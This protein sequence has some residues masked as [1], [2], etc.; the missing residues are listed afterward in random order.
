MLEFADL[1]QQISGEMSVRNNTTT[2]PDH[3]ESTTI[4]ENTSWFFPQKIDHYIQK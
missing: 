4:L 1:K 3:L 2:G